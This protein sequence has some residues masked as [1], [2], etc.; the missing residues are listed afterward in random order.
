MLPSPPSGTL[1][2]LLDDWAARLTVERSPATVRGYLADVTRLVRLLTDDRKVAPPPPAAGWQ[3]PCRR[4]LWALTAEHLTGD[5]LED[6]CAAAAAGRSPATVRRYKASWAGLLGWLSR[7]GVD[8][9]EFADLDLPDPRAGKPAP[10]ALTVDQAGRIVEAAREGAGSAR[11]P[12][13]ARDVAAVAVLLSTGVRSAELCAARIGDLDGAAVVPGGPP[14]GAHRRLRVSGKGMRER[15]LPLH[16]EAAAEVDRF[17]TERVAGRSDGPWFDGPWRAGRFT[18]A[19][20]AAPLLVRSDGRPLTADALSWMVGRLFAAAGVP[21]PPGAAVHAL[22]HTFAVAA[23][24]AGAH[25]ATVR[26]ALGHENLATT[27]RYL[28]VS[29]ANLAAAADRHP[30]R[31]LLRPDPT[32]DG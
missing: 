13:P 18:G 16:R 10:K 30:S 2:P 25:L 11:R 4:H 6:A 26:A 29:D 14:S 19:W 8:L 9:V 22:R 27:S 23:L 17:L 12:W 24:D 15:T 1:G 31:T 28:L 5:R 20:S 3:H 21:R 7:R 32:A